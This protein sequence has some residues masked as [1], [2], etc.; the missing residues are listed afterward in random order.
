MTTITLNLE[1]L[2]FNYLTNQTETLWEYSGNNIV[3]HEVKNL[4]V[5]LHNLLQGSPEEKANYCAY[6]L[7]KYEGPSDMLSEETLDLICELDS[8]D[9]PYI[10]DI[11]HQGRTVKVVENTALNCVLDTEEEDSEEWE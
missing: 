8:M 4:C 1:D 10:I 7:G 3:Q 11:Q 6:L 2:I 9:K 5:D